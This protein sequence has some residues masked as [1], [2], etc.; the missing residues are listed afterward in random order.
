MW[1]EQFDSLPYCSAA[2]SSKMLKE[3]LNILGKIGCLVCLLG[4][5][6]IVLHSPKEQELQTMEELA[7]K[8]Q[9]PGMWDGPCSVTIHQ[10][11]VAESYV[12]DLRLLLG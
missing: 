9:D 6:V 1:N 8:L 2:L 7:V 12:V 3:R 10:S 4:S 11:N 5:T